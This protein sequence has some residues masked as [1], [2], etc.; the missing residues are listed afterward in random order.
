MVTAERDNTIIPLS[1]YNHRPKG[2]VVASVDAHLNAYF[3]LSV[4]GV[5]QH[6][7][8]ITLPVEL[9]RNVAVDDD[10]VLDVWVSDVVP[11]GCRLMFLQYSN[12]SSIYLG[13]IP[14]DFNL[15]PCESIKQPSSAVAELVNS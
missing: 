11:A 6:N 14:T 8:T 4:S 12:E 7:K 13:Q 3:L 15:E 10:T 9:Y 1:A 5:P 2:V